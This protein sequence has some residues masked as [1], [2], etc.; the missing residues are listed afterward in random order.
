ML[1]KVTRFFR[2]YKQFGITIIAIIISLG[3]DLGGL[4]V[5]AHW[6]LGVTAIGNAIPLVKGMWEDL[7]TGKYGIDLLAATAIVTSVILHEYWTAIIIVLMLTGGESLEDYA[8]HR[9]RTELDALLTHAPKIAHVLRGRK[10]VDI[11]IKQVRPGDKV[12]IKPGEIVPVD[13]IILEGETSFDESSLTGE[14]LPVD[15]KQDDQILSGAVN[16]EGVI[17]MRAVHSA[18]DSQYEQIIKLVKNAASTQ[19]PFVRLTDRYS[20]P[21]TVVSFA[22]AGTAWALSGD[23]VRFLQVIVVAT[24]CPLLLAAPIALISGMSRAAKHGII[25]KTGSALERLAETKTIAFDKTGTLTHGT[26]EVGVITVIKPFQRDEVLSAAAALE[27]NSTHI[28]AR[29]IVAAAVSKGLKVP[30]AKHLRERPGHGL[31]GRVGKYNVIAG[32]L[33]FLKEEGVHLPAAF[34]ES[35]LKTTVTCVAI[36]GQLAGIISFSDEI[37]A[38]SKPML[39]RL[40]ELGIKKFLMV[41]GDNK[42]AAAS[43]AQQMSITEVV[44]NALPA[45]KVRAIESVQPR[46]VAFVGDGVNDAPV[47]TAS[48]IGIALGARGSTAASESADVVI[49]LDDVGQVAKGVEIAK[50]TFTIAKQAILIGIGMSIAL[51]LIFFT[52]KFRPVYGAALQELVDVSVIFIALRAHGG[53]RESKTLKKLKTQTV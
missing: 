38:E 18:A 1:K 52:G 43:V 7:R 47:L 23:P 22:I 4:D 39:E 25:I 36:D 37:R 33:D 44:D 12:I 27:Q 5:I 2:D 35:D 15:K 26:P 30:K 28:L 10:I 19:S 46:P 50:H 53:F 17:T 41:T 40:R 31:S 51:E 45:D 3:L 48:D 8:E 42:A 24:P 14:S 21:F 34:K 11:A 6:V 13:G 9:A 49:M 20:I 32:K 16:I 29:A